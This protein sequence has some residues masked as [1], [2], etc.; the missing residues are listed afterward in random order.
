MDLQLI[1]DNVK[2]ALKE[3]KAK[4]DLSLSMLKGISDKTITAN[5]T[6]NEKA[7]LSGTKWFEES[8]KQLETKIKVKWNFKEGENLPKNS[9]VATI[10]GPANAIL[11][12]ERTA[13]NFLQFMSGISSKTSAIKK[14]I[15]NKNIK[16]L[17]TRKT[18][19]GMR[20]E[21]KYATLIGGAQNHRFDLAD[22]LMIKDN[23]IA[24]A[25]GIEKLFFKKNLKKGKFLE[26]EV[27]KLSQIEAALKLKP[28]IIM[29]DNLRYSSLIK[30]ISMISK[31]CM[32]EVS[33]IKGEKHFKEVSKLD[34]DFISLGDLTKNISSIDFS[35]NF[36]V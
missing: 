9:L 18:I 27:K 36:N 24:A 3:D 33:G 8:F 13:L 15:K 7:I 1:K 23:H 19:P 14:T 34:I 32:V 12:G 16:L 6:V 35:L 2:R 31:K 5:L 26:I 22:G 25:E 10:R 20:F 17:D 30:A 29:L 28:D 11:S 4:N 21:Q